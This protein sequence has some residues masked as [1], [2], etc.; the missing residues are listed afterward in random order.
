MPQ[1]LGD[2]YEEVLL[3]FLC[4]RTMNLALHF[5]LSVTVCL[6]DNTN[7]PP[8][9]SEFFRSSSLF[10][11]LKAFIAINPRIYFSNAS[12]HLFDAVLRS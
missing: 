10:T 1:C 11:Y 3:F 2:M 7:L 6:I 9:L 5:S 12:L 4:P 8:T